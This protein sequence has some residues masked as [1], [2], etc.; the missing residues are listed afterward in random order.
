MMLHHRQH[1]LVARLDAGREKGIGDQ[2]DRFGAALGED[3]LVF[4]RGVDEFLHGAARG[5]I[6]VGGRAGQI[7]HA[8]MDIG[9][10]G[11][12]AKSRIASSTARGFCAE[13]PLS[14]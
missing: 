11:A 3:D 5:F 2:I 7:M 12:S 13:A 9:V 1:D 6:G 4:V 10:F 8:A 14:R